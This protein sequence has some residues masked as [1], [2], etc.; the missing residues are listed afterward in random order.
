[1]LLDSYIRK[2]LLEAEDSCKHRKA[3]TGNLKGLWKYRIMDYRLLVKREDNK[4][5]IIALDFERRSK[6]YK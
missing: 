5:I 3:L 4:L 2:N 1:M 6:G